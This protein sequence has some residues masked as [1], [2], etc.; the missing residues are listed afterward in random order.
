MRTG[1]IYLKRALWSLVGSVFCR[2]GV[3][4]RGIEIDEC[5]GVR[6][7]KRDVSISSR[8][9]ISRWP[10]WT[11]EDIMSRSS[12]VG[13]KVKLFSAG[14]FCSGEFTRASSHVQLH[15]SGPIA[16]GSGGG[17]RRFDYWAGRKTRWLV[18]G[19]WLWWCVRRCGVGVL[20]IS[21][22]SERDFEQLL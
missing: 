20:H 4:E 10:V 12:A 22:G 2:V 11:V 9:R 6:R 1:L 17:G 14:L 5:M 8:A 19:P 16:G 18:E 21:C 7:F 13:T 15:R 3:G